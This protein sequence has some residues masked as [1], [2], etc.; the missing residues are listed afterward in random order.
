[1]AADQ[2]V[3]RFGRER[4]VRLIIDLDHRRAKRGQVPPGHRYIRGPGLGGHQ[5]RRRLRDPRKQLAPA[6][7]DVKR[8]G[9]AGHPLR[10]QP[11]VT[12]GRALLGGPAVEPGEIPACHRLGRGLG[13]QLPERR[14]RR[15]DGSVIAGGG[16]RQPIS[17]VRRKQ[18]LAQSRPLTE[19]ARW[20][21]QVAA[22]WTARLAAIKQ[23]A[24]GTGG[25][26]GR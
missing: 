16:T 19:T 7:L 15:H 10:E 1:M 12:P 24:E 21:N 22:E 11:G 5:G 8:H 18:G 14:R 26:G 17:G 25:D 3:E 23:L 2:Q 20:M 6:G 4:Q 9:G 13:Q